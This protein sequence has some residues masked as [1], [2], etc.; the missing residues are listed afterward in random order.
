MAFVNSAAAKYLPFEWEEIK[1]WRASSSSVC[2]ESASLPQS[3][4]QDHKETIRNHKISI[5]CLP[6]SKVKA[7]KANDKD[8]A[9]KLNQ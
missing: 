5:L 9:L 3:N 4:V 2:Q 1:I 6:L 7:H 8:S